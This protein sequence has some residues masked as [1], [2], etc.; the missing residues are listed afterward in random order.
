MSDRGPC[1]TTPALALAQGIFS[2][3]NGVS[4][5]AGT[6]DD[7]FYI[8]LGATFDSLNFRPNNFFA[9]ATTA[10]G[11]VLPVLSQTQDA[12]DSSQLRRGYGLRVTT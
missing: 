8:D 10:S 12:N 9:G 2:L 4:V 5:F 6:V 3:G 1:R 11:G 7:P